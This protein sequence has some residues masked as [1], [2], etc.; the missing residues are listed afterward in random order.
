LVDG[1]FAIAMTLLV[2]S[3]NVPQIPYPATNAQILGFFSQYGSPILHLCF[4]L[5]SPGHVL[6]S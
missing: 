5:S 6:E 2:L 1:I 4:E 3:L